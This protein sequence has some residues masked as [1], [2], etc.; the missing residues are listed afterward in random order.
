MRVHV[1][2]RV[3]GGSKEAQCICEGLSFGVRGGVLC[4][5]CLELVLS[6]AT[7]PHDKSMQIDVI[8]HGISFDVEM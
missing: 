2:H 6:N 5:E 8:S 7:I 4:Y 1:D 3:R